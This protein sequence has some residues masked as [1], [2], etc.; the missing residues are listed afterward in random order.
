M[1]I[2]WQKF[3]PANPVG[4]GD[5]FQNAEPIFPENSGLGWFIG[6][7]KTC[8]IPVIRLRETATERALFWIQPDRIMDPKGARRRIDAKIFAALAHFIPHDVNGKV[9]GIEGVL[10]AWKDMKPDADTAMDDIRMIRASLD[11]LRK[12]TNILSWMTKNKPEHS[13]AFTLYELYETFAEALPRHFKPLNSIQFKP[14]QVKDASS[15]SIMALPYLISFWFFG[16]GILLSALKKNGETVFLSFNNSEDH[17]H[18]ILRI[19]CAAFS[20]FLESQAN[21]DVPEIFWDW[22]TLLAH[23]NGTW[24]NTQDGIE[25]VIPLK[26]FTNP[27]TAARTFAFGA[28]E[29]FDSA[30]ETL[31]VVDN[32]SAQTI[33]E[34][35]IAHMFD[36]DHALIGNSVNPAHREM[37]IDLLA[38]I[39]DI[40]L[41][42]SK[43]KLAK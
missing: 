10:D 16:T 4:F 28:K 30:D 8:V 29:N 21:N 26:G 20:S 22:L 39:R 37:I 36:F 31:R 24:K 14:P 40:H 32:L 38:S 41:E 23:Q 42:D 35:L 13:R 19:Q 11:P 5:Y 17:Q 27:A 1:S 3:E 15:V 43:R 18:L 6:K 2:T 25:L 12:L 7:L 9:M 33:V 34:N